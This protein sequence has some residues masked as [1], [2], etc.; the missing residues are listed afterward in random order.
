MLYLG[1]DQHKSQLTVNLRDEHGN[2]I[3]KRQVNTKHSDI[4]DYFG[5]LAKQA[6]KHRGFMAVVEVCGFNHWL[7][8][9]LQRRCCREIVVVQPD[10]SAVTKTDQRDANTLCELLWNNR[11]QAVDGKN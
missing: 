5:K 1:I 3:D 11:K 6:A 7:L 8:E 9:E 2:V 10:D 4:D